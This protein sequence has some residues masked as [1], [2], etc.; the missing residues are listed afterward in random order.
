MFAEP[1][2]GHLIEHDDWKEKFLLELESECGGRVIGLP[3]FNEKDDRKKAFDAAFQ[4]L[5][6]G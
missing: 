5:I 1:K 6:G 4:R 2:G 3:F